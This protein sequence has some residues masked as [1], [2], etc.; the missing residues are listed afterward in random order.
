[1]SSEGSFAQRPKRAYKRERAT[2]GKKG[3]VDNRWLEV[4]SEDTGQASCIW[5]CGSKQPKMS[6]QTWHRLW[7][8]G[9]P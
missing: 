4:L 3:T 5:T 1:M 6:G 7:R 9:K 8:L 2:D